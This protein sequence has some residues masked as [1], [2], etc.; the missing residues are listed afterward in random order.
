MESNIQFKYEVALTFAGEDRAFAEAV[1]TGLKSA[2]VN[3]FYDDF[4]IEDLWGQDLSV[5]L[6]D[7]YRRSSQF[8]IMIISEN[9]VRKMWPSHE[10]QQ[11]IERMIQDHGKTYILPVRLN[12][13]KGEV[14]GFS[15]SISYLAVN[16]NDPQIV[17][18][19]F[20]R[21]IGRKPDS[22]KKTKTRQ[23]MPKIRL[24]KMKKSYT[25]REKNQFLKASFTEIV[26]IIDSFASGTKDEYPHFDYEMEKITSRK[27][28]FTLYNN[29]Q[30]VTQFKIW[31]GGIS[32]GNSIAFS[33]GRNV[34]VDND[35]TM[36]ESISIEEHEGELKLKPM[37]FGLFG[38][39]A[40]KPMSPR[41]SAD[42][43]W[44][45]VTKHLQ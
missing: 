2:G 5:K 39:N 10:R 11:A 8:C 45:V 12:G 9:Y 27:V 35:N 7:V 18:D 3:V 25:D 20:L 30:Q 24:P 33:H 42:Y 22:P 37:G 36:N 6:R 44:E 43:L 40:D 21:K 19:A 28:L 32:G 4:Y 13:F 14:P 26:N 29:D 1:A 23:E 17:V 15:D 38:N 41:Q 31:I 16:S 34:N